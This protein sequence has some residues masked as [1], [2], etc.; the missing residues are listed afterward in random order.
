M[1]FWGKRLN[2]VAVVSCLSVASGCSQVPTI[3]ETIG[4]T[5]PPSIVMSDIVHRV[6]CELAD[7]FD[8]RIGQQDF[9]WLQNWTA[10][11]DL[12]LQVNNS[13]GVSPAVSYTKYYK[14]AFNY[15]AGSSSLT[16]AT[17]ISAV[18]QSLTLQAGA[19]YSEQ[20][21]RAETITFTLSLREL[22]DWR[23]RRNVEVSDKFG[24]GAAE[25]Y[26]DISEQELRGNLGLKEWIDA[27]LHPVIEHELQAGIHPEPVTAAA[28]ATPTAPGGPKPQGTVEKEITPPDVP[29]KIARPQIEKAAQAAYKSASNTT[30]SKTAVLTADKKVIAALA[31]PSIAQYRPILTPELQARLNQNIL[32]LFDAV[33]RVEDDATDASAANATAQGLKVAVDKLSDDAKVHQADIDQAQYAQRVAAHA[34]TDA[35]N[36][37]SVAASIEKNITTFK[38]DPPINALGHSVQ[39]I[40]TYGASMTPNWTLLMWKGPGLTVPGASLSGIRTN[41]LNIALGPTS[42]EQ[43]SLLLR[44]TIRNV[45][46]PQ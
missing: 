11:V 32:T 19:N 28:K 38:P 46:G 35:A 40:V 44:Q 39:F 29:V 41:I 18:T 25:H 3:G 27:S 34:E 42:D 8:E 31:S 12:T 43:D 21:Q 10:K 24:P 36:E 26:C 45:L 1:R 33:K 30:A 6:K 4:T 37:K 17:A 2:G 13:G 16:S 5:D 15:S 7:A 20:A 22:R 23:G 14:N 9:L